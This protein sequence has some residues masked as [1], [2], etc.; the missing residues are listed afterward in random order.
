MEVAYDSASVDRSPWVLFSEV[1]SVHACFVI[2]SLFLVCFFLCV[3]LLLVVLACISL[4]G[5]SNGLC[6]FFGM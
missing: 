2:I 6:G 1:I 5:N 3:F 4:V